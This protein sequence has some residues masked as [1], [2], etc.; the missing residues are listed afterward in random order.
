[1]LPKVPLHDFG[2]TLIRPLIFIAEEEIRKFAQMYGFARIVCQCP[3]GQVSLR[4]RVK[5]A[6][7]I[8]KR[9]FPT[10]GEI[11]RRHRC[12]TALIKHSVSDAPKLQFFAQLGYNRKMLK[13]GL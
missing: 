3:V 6:I 7:R 13:K 1:M 5:G 2:V 9:H 11:C 10:R 4:R 8:W 12:C